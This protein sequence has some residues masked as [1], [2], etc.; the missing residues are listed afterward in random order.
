MKRLLKAFVFLI[1]LIIGVFAA[2]ALCI[3]VMDADAYRPELAEMLSKKMGRTVKLNGSIAFSLGLKGIRVSVEDV[4]LANPSGAS[5]P[6]LANVGKL[7][8]GIDTKPLL[9]RRLSIKELSIE[10]ADILLETDAEG[11]HNWDFS[12]SGAPETEKEK[13]TGTASSA[14]GAALSIDKLKIANSQLGFRNKEGKRSGANVR[15]MVLDMRATGAEI[16]LTG[17]VNGVPVDAKI[18][19][20]IADLLKIEPFSADIDGTYNLFSVMGRGK[21]DI[22]AQKAVF[23]SYE[24][25]ARKTKIAGAFEATWGGARPTLRGTLNSDHFDPADFKSGILTTDSE[26]K[27]AVVEAPVAQDSKRFFSNDPLPLD[28]LKSADAAL[29]IAI[30]EYPVNKGTLKKVRAKLI[31]SGG[32]LLLEPVKAYVGAVPVD[33]RIALDASKAP[34]RLD[35]G[36]IAKNVDLGD[37]QRLSNM[38]SFMTGKA[39]ADIQLMGEGNSSHE[40]A[41]TL[42][43]VIL[44]TAE[45][46]E[47]FTGAASGVSSLLA[48]VFSVSSK[49]S[50]LNCLAARFIV[51][52]GVMNDNGILIDS[53]TSTVLAKG[54]IN[55]GS[56]TVGMTL[57]AHSKLVDIGGL[58]PSVHVGGTLKKPSYSVNASGVVKNVVNTLMEGNPDIISSNVPGIQTPPAGQNACVYTLEHPKKE[59]QRTILSTDPLS[60]A[61]QAINS[62]FKGIM[63]Q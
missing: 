14:R 17:D 9:D 19:T 8:L 39:S 61:G 57:H 42:G 59:A 45:K 30:G 10:N 3:S 12:G 47:I 55:L 28:M 37:L 2:L 24:L 7:E 41:S 23:S 1:F 53:A 40:I 36:M 21:I 54:Q 4:A 56:E 29:A 52:G 58:I 22:K 33:V 15:S 31:L 63:G 32:N 60:K 43:G 34:A 26:G 18:R 62:L 51:R 44:V 11:K 5:R 35:L 27:V 6:L 25:T 48:S 38:T 49:D 13:G 50:T 20:D 16:T 46:G